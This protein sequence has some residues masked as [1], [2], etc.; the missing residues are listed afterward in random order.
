M[1]IKGQSKTT[2]TRFCQLIHK[3][4]TYWGEKLDWC[5]TRKIWNLRLWSVVET[6]QSASS[7]TSTQEKM[8]ERLNSGES[9]TIF[10]N[11]SCIVITVLTKSGRKAW[12]EEE[13]ET[14]KD[15]SIVLIHQEQ[16]CSSDLFK[17]IQDAVSLI[18]HTGQCRYSGRFLQVHL[19][20]GCA[21]NLHSIIKSG[22]I[23]CL[24]IPW[25]K[26]T[27]ILT[28]T[29]W[30][31][32]E[33][34]S[35]Q[36]VLGR[37]QLFSEERF[38]VLSDTIECHHPL[39]NT[40]IWCPES[41]SD[42]NWRSHIRESICVTSASSEVFFETW[43]DDW[44]QKLFDNQREKLFN[45]QKVHNQANQIQTQIMTERWIRCL[46]SKRSVPFSGNRNTFFSWRS[47]ETR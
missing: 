26:T 3:N 34:T 16:S 24:W 1:P 8:M 4:Y 38:E 7:W 29:T 28:R 18:F 43:L 31:S 39:R 9:K 11:I 25:R 22:L 12:Q 15:F 14:R 42:G 36:S 10:R 13:E 32:M 20:V 41:C 30:Q 17:V 37:H 33:E 27:R 21:I 35:K 23:P 44:V 2:K 6:D 45:N 47:C 5:W 46:P 40:P 19:H